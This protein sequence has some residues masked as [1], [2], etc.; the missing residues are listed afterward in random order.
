MTLDPSRR[1]FCTMGAGLALS[2]MAGGGVHAEAASPVADTRH[3]RV[4]GY[5]DRDIKVFKG[6][7][8]G[9]DTSNRR[10]RPAEKPAAWRG[11]ADATAYGHA[12]PQASPPVESDGCWCRRR[13]AR[14]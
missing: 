1:T 10:F 2:A 11:V 14:P 3:G 7:R 8:Y 12:S 9:A 13:S 5:V 6:V 4:R